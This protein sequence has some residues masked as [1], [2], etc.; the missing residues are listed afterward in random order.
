MNTASNTKKGC[1]SPDLFEEM[2]IDE[3]L[4]IEHLDKL[5]N[6][7]PKHEVITLDDSFDDIDIDAHLD[8]IDKEMAT[9]P[10]STQI[11]RDFKEQVKSPELKPQTSTPKLNVSKLQISKK[12]TQSK[13]NFGSSAASK[14]PDSDDDFEDP[15]SIFAKSSQKRPPS[16]V[17]LNISTTSPV[18]SSKVSSSS[19]KPPAIN[20]ISIGKLKKMLPTINKGKFKIKGKFATVAEKLKTLDTS[21]YLVITVKDITGDLNVQVQSDIVAKFAETTPERLKELRESVLQR[22]K[23]AEAEIFQVNAFCE[24]V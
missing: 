7:Q 20:T 1:S 18:S 21:F 9:M 22:D 16:F 3:E 2:K 13:L 5:E 12:L 23:A 6:S 19:Q 4:L 8:H 15:F 11:I 17:P 10:C 14:G 24:F